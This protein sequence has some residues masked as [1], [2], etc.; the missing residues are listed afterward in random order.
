M[1]WKWRPINSMTKAV[2][3][4]TA[5]RIGTRMSEDRGAFENRLDFFL[6]SYF[7]ERLNAPAHTATACISRGKKTS[8]F[9]HGFLAGPSSL[10]GVRASRCGE[11]VAQKHSPTVRGRKARE[12]YGGRT[13]TI[14]TV[15]M[16]LPTSETM[17]EISGKNEGIDA[18]TPF[19]TSSTGATEVRRYVCL[20]PTRGISR[21]REGARE[22][23]EPL[24][25]PGRFGKE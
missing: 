3:K 24:S 22:R 9:R 1:I 2:K 23:S 7:G 4:E 17:T 8:A 10:H 21:G 18:G 6:A 20:S 16:V 11:D 12:A 14:K 15:L 19:F 13:S 5:G 25:A